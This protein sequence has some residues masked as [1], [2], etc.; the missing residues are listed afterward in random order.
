MTIQTEVLFRA[1]AYREAVGSV[2]H[3]AGSLSDQSNISGCWL[4]DTVS[5][6]MYQPLS[7]VVGYHHFGD[8]GSGPSGASVRQFAF[9]FLRLM[10]LPLNS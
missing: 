9:K 2:T 6:V 1:D 8:E 7:Q 5:L 3:A 10:R 4:V